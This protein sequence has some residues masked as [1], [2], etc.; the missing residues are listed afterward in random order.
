M[1]DGRDTCIKVANRKSS[2]DAGRTTHGIHQ[3]LEG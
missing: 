3:S 1:D 2:G